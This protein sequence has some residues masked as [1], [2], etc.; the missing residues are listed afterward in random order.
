MKIPNGRC[1]A[2]TADGMRTHSSSCD[3]RSPPLRPEEQHDSMYRI[4]INAG[5]IECPTRVA[6]PFACSKSSRLFYI[7]N[8]HEVGATDSHYH[9]AGRFTVYRLELNLSCWMVV[10]SD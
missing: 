2:V 7:V 10:G 9:L 5:E 3:Y 4:G 1:F 6:I 8:S